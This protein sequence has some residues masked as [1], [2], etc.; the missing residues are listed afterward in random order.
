MQNNNKPIYKKKI[1]HRIIVICNAVFIVCYVVFM[2]S[3]YALIYNLSLSIKGNGNTVYL[4]SKTG[5]APSIFTKKPN[6]ILCSDSIFRI[7]PD[8]LLVQNALNASG[9][10]TWKQSGSSVPIHFGFY[11]DKRAYYWSFRNMKLFEID[12]DSSDVPYDFNTLQYRCNLG[13]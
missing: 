8:K 4:Y 5:F 1:L 9:L 6:E 12:P 7:R 11:K 13:N 2:A 3:S 10:W